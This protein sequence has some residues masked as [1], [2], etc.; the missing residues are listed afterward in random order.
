MLERKILRYSQSRKGPK[1]VS[2]LGILQPIRDAVKLILKF[3][4]GLVEVKILEFFLFPIMSLLMMV[5]FWLL[6]SPSVAFFKLSKSLLFIILFLRLKVFPILGSGWASKRKYSILGAIRGAAQRISYEVIL[7]FLLIF[8][9]FFFKELNFF[10]NKNLI[11]LFFFWFVFFIW[12]L[13]IICETNRAPFDFAEGERELVS[14]FK[15]EYGAFLF[16]LLFL[17]E[18]GMILFLSVFSCFY[19]LKIKVI[20]LSWFIAFIFLWVRTSFPRFRYDLL[21]FFC[22]GILLPFIFFIYFLLNYL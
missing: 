12:L 21:M 11:L 13:V 6:L 14:G 10:L 22:W 19:F 9:L 4:G 15:V 2:I 1:K 18:Y 17:A 20:W 16:A 7:V 3:F 5:F 8:L